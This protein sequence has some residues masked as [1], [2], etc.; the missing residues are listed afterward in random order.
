[1][2]VHVLTEDKNDDTKD[3]FYKVHEQVFVHSPSTTWK[4]WYE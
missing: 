4:Y 2:N 1:M 3:S